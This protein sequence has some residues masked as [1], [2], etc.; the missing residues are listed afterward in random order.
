MLSRNKCIGL[1]LTSSL[2]LGAAQAQT[3]DDLLAEL[4]QAMKLRAPAEPY[5]PDCEATDL[6]CSKWA[7]F[8]K[9]R[10]YPHQT[11][12]MGNV[13]EDRLV[14]V[15]AEPPSRF[16]KSELQEF[17]KDL[18][19]DE[20]VECT[21]MRWMIGV[22]GWLE[23]FV[24]TIKSTQGH[25]S[26]DDHVLYD[27][28]ALLSEA[29]YGTALAMNVERIGSANTTVLA[30]PD[31]IVRP[32]DLSSWLTDHELT[33]RTYT[34]SGWKRRASWKQA[35]PVDGE[36]VH[37]SN[38]GTLVVFTL[39]IDQLRAAERDASSLDHAL[40][41]FRVFSVASDVVLGGAW[42]K[43]GLVAIVA[44]GR[45]AAMTAMSPLRFETFRILASEATDE[46]AQSYERNRLFSGKLNSGDY[47]LMDWAPI[48]LSPSLINQEFGALLNITDQ[49]LKSWSEAGS[50]QY[51]Y[52]D[53]PLKP[54]KFVLSDDRISDQLRRDFGG[55]GVLFNWNTAGHTAVSDQYEG[56]NVITANHTSA[57]PVTYRAGSDQDSFSDVSSAREEKYAQYENDAYSYFANLEDPNLARAAQ[58]TLIYQ[59]FREAKRSLSSDANLIAGGPAHQGLAEREKA[60]GVLVAEAKSLIAD[61]NDGTLSPFGFEEVKQEYGTDEELEA[62]FKHFSLSVSTLK[63]QIDEIRQVW[64]QRSDDELARIFVSP[65]I[66]VREIES[67]TNQLRSLIAEWEVDVR[68]YNAAVS[69]FNSRSTTLQKKF[70]TW[71]DEN[72]DRL[73]LEADTQ[74]DIEVS[75]REALPPQLAEAREQQDAESA[76]LDAQASKLEQKY[77]PVKELEERVIAFQSFTGLLSE[78]R[79]L[80]SFAVDLDGIRRGFMKANAEEP[81]GSIKTPSVVLSWDSG[82]INTIG[83]HNLTASTLRFERAPTPTLIEIVVGPKGR[84][85]RYDNSV[86]SKVEGNEN[87][88]ARLVE[89]GKI[90]DAQKLLQAV[91]NAAAPKTRQS[92]LKL[93]PNRDRYSQR[94]LDLIDGTVPASQASLRQSIAQVE[95]MVAAAQ[96]CTFIMRAASGEQIIA[97]HRLKPPPD[98]KIVSGPKKLAENLNQMTRDVAGRPVVFLNHPAGFASGM[99][100]NVRTPFGTEGAVRKLVGIFKRDPTASNDN[101]ARISHLDVAG[102]RV[103]LDLSRPARS[104]IVA[105]FLSQNLP[106]DVPPKFVELGRDTVERLLQDADT[107]LVEIGNAP[108]GLRIDFGRSEDQVSFVATPRG[109][110]SDAIELLK[111]S[112]SD[113]ISDV[114]R[115]RSDAKWVDVITE[116]KARLE[117]LKEDDLVGR[118]LAVIKLGSQTE[119]ISRNGILVSPAANHG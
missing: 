88:L 99:M 90:E 85:L 37:L 64:P 93:D 54:A 27:R 38:D 76:K 41:A 24:L 82:N 115:V 87:Q 15:L 23:D 112:I 49:I 19:G 86:A 74:T 31:L 29:L 119:V 61:I 72:L 30:A 5:D 55:S 59:L 96:C 9:S 14:L 51:E 63:R 17:V 104:S 4:E 109:K 70:E 28:V 39:S 102:K 8:R 45:E 60:I 6:S 111:D 44:R 62:A 105:R 20:L 116:V 42:D 81:D 66:E 84:T 114:D 3:Q 89:H 35:K 103:V 25:S 94:I 92:V 113:A 80:A 75:V 106:S 65:D 91:S 117:K 48:Y 47:H 34:S 18:F 33:W 52:F 40:E 101:V 43:N 53:Y 100:R 1:A 11:L 16:P 22:D 68:A 46:L 69:D 12:A 118:F 36:F 13:S 73:I 7:E 110:Q 67:K 21:Q 97:T 57:L 56:L 26:L 108:V 2:V 50:I 32:G 107:Q 98:L 10:P 83:G 95:S 58:Y 77:R 79:E 78:V 71:L